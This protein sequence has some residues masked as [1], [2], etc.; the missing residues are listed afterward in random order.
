MRVIFFVADTQRH[1][2]PGSLIGLPRDYPQQAHSR[3]SSREIASEFLILIEHK[4]FMRR[5]LRRWS[6]RG[7][8]LPNRSQ[9]EVLVLRLSEIFRRRRQRRHIHPMPFKRE[10][11]T[12]QGDPAA[13]F[14]MM[15]GL[16]INLIAP[17]I[18]A[19]KSQEFFPVPLYICRPERL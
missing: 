5:R 9:G 3:P 6:R 16:P 11:I 4:H 8:G 14:A 1:D 10:W 15:Q 7:S 2:A 17:H 18:K 13:G 19:S 12:R